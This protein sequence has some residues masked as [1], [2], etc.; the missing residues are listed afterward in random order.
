MNK[1]TVI[2]SLV[3]AAASSAYGQA[4]PAAGDARSSWLSK[5]EFHHEELTRDLPR[6]AENDRQIAGT[7]FAANDAALSAA[8]VAEQKARHPEVKL[9][10]QHMS[11]EH[12]LMNKQVRELCERLGIRAQ[13]SATSAALAVRA[14]RNE[15]TLA[16]L[17]AAAFDTA[18]VDQEVAQH[19]ELLAL[20]D[21]TLI[22]DAQ[23]GELKDLLIRIRPTLAAHL[24]HARTVQHEL[25]TPGSGL[26]GSMNK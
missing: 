17:R 16:K 20:L 2:A 25:A 8:K 7:L 18:Y 21:D 13:Q 4:L 5:G 19:A 11:A 23:N 24:E 10:A 26:S 3:A 14:T 6:T 12:R 1:T 9:L 22:P 15:A